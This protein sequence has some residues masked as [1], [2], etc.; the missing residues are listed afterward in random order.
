M[1]TRVR[2]VH[3]INGGEFGGA[4]RYVLNLVRRLDPA[5][6]DPA[7]ACGYEGRFSRTLAAA[8]ANVW[9]LPPGPRGVFA[10]ASRLRAWGAHLVHTHGVRGNFFGRLAAW[11][12]GIP[13]IVTTVHSHFALDYPEPA[14][15][16]A[17]G[18]L[19]AFTAPLVTRYVAVS[20]ALRELLVASGVDP[21]RVTVIPNGVDT[22]AFRPRPG[23]RAHL[24][25]AL[26]LGDDTRL[27]GMV[28]RL[29]PVKGHRLFLETAAAFLRDTQAP[30][31]RFLVVGGGEPAYR[32]E[33]EALTGALGVSGAVT[34]LGEQEDVA[35]ILAGLD[36]VVVPSRFEGFC[37]SALEA[38]AC[39]VPVVA[40]RV[41]AIPELITDGA[42][43][44]LAPPGD[45]GALAAAL[46]RLLGDP[47]LAARLAEGGL[48]TARR[49]SLEAFVNRTAA[50]Y[51]ALLTARA[52]APPP[53]GR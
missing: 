13:V 49:F 14:K 24:V 43:G 44:L 38:M 15:R 11:D 48:E 3:V 6:F 39:G 35:G 37:L 16:V 46:R 7:V 4:E 22:T 33:L 8:G 1:R 28:A 9:V 42:N 20:Q 31:V 19:E 32:R 23:A 36:A 12:A 26:G 27:V 40:T 5:S 34:F 45:A 53:W 51:H 21:R 2:I 50:L 47:L 17:Y 52:V 18:V 30:P 10:L 25:Q 29:H 41:G